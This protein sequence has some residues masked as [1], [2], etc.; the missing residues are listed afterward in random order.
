MA[1]D[2]WGGT[3]LTPGPWRF[4]SGPSL[5]AAAALLTTALA[6]PARALPVTGQSVPSLVAFDQSMQDFMGQWGLG[7]GVLAVSKDGCVVYQR[8]FGTWMWGFTPL[9]ENTPMRLASVEKPLT[10]AAIRHLAKAGRFDLDD[11]VFDRGQPEGGL[12]DIDPWPRLLDYRYSEITVQ[13]LIDHK[14]GWDRDIFGDPMFKAIEIA[15]SMGVPSPPGRVRT[16]QFML[17]QFLQHAPG[18]KYAY[19]NFGYMLLGLIVEQESGR[20]HD[21]YIKHELLS[22]RMWVHWNEL[23]M[24]RTFRGWQ[25]L[26][27]PYYV[28]K[29][30]RDN[31][32]DPDE[33]VP[34]AYGS[35]DQESMVGHGNL[36]SSA[37]PLLRFMDLY[38]MDGTPI[39]EP[40]DNNFAGL[41][42]GTST[43]MQQRSDGINIVVLFSEHNAE[44]DDHLG[45]MMKERIAAIINGGGLS[46]PSRCVDGNWVDLSGSGLGF[47]GYND[48]FPGMGSAMATMGDGGTLHLRSGPS[49][50]TGTVTRRM[51]WD[52]PNGPVRVGQL[53]AD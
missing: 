30:E 44:G 50:W 1:R 11:F 48:P 21:E 39:T 49:S 31:V 25:N 9:A 46:W 51:R 42:H 52:A 8:G 43:C 38:T 18:S 47:G 23:E 12:L 16:A 29:A 24:G 20:R 7:A 17:G 2:D 22:P 10:A 34:A 53:G 33:E 13:H 4:R 32:Y 35:W 36:I 27:E 19:S 15:E 5:L 28:S 45:W 6:G 3:R 14:G 37:V 41:L 40:T 26:R